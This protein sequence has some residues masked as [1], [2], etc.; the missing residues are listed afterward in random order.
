MRDLVLCT[1]LTVDDGATCNSHAGLSVRNREGV[2]RTFLFDNQDHNLA[3]QVVG[4]GNQEYFLACFHV[5]LGNF[6]EK[7]HCREVE[8]FRFHGDSWPSFLDIEDQP[9]LHGEEIHLDEGPWRT[10]RHSFEHVSGLY[11]TDPV[12]LSCN[13][14]AGGSLHKIGESC[15]PN[16]KTYRALN[17]FLPHPGLVRLGDEA[18]SMEAFLSYEKLSQPQFVM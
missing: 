5:F 11:L 6:I 8:I 10:S 7:T 18:E 2:V 4:R 14:Q 3:V 12:Q 1:R 17:R 15:V 16:A 9:R 13:M